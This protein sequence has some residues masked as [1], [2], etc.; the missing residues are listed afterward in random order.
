MQSPKNNPPIQLLH[1]SSTSCPPVKEKDVNTSST[2]ESKYDLVVMVKSAVYNF[3]DRQTFRSLYARIN[4]LS[5]HSAYPLR[6]GIVFLVG[7]PRRSGNATFERDGFNVT[8]AN[9]AGRSLKYIEHLH[10][11][12]HRHVKEEILQYEYLLVV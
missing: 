6:I 2:L 3:Q 1:V 7:L 8:L 11:L 9:R 12:I 10:P 5:E 4:D